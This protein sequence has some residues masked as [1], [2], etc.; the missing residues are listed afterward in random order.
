MIARGAASSGVALVVAGMIGQELGA[1]I[2]VR[3]FPETGPL[4]MVML[5]LVFSAVLLLAIARPRLSGRTRR[6]WAAVLAFGVVLAAM[7]SLF[8]LA[9]ERLALGVAVT[10]EVL[11]P[12]VLSIVASRRASAWLW[13]VLALGGVVALGGGGWE[14]LDPLG[15]VFALAAALTWA[16]YI[17]ASAR[18]GRTFERI[19]GLALAMAVGAVLSLPLGVATAG[20]AL[21]RVDVLALGAAVAVLSSALPY[22]LELIALR[23]IS[24][25]VFG[26]LMSASPAIAALVGLAVLGQQLSWLQVAGIVLVIG[27]SAGA[28]ASAG[29]RAVAEAV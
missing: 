1:A 5:R 3:V 21:V 15:V 24:A 6:D 22:A 18:V 12:L 11:G 20:S 23:R 14:S 19:D 10:I 13:A 9:I 8:Y 4:G 16:L 29:R 25:S 27:A 17:L 7:N 2:A 26:I 28:V